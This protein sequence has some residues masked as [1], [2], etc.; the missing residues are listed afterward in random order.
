MQEIPA[1]L[2]FFVDTN[3]IYLE[4]EKSFYVH[5]KKVDEKTGRLKDTNQ[6]K[7]YLDRF[8]DRSPAHIWYFDYYLSG[9]HLPVDSN[10]I[11]K[12]ILN[13]CQNY[14][15]SI[16]QDAGNNSNAEKNSDEIYA[17]T[18]NF[19]TSSMDLYVLPKTIRKINNGF[20]V[21]V[22]VIT[23]DGEK[24]GNRITYLFYNNGNINESEDK[25]RWSQAGALGDK[26][27]LKSDKA[28]WTIYRICKKFL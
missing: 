8:G 19:F 27:K 7:F 12:E 18:W 22:K 11:A 13:V 21:D 26:R 17:C 4:S 3:T 10:N 16:L 5:V 9:K 6:W 24:S 2:I 1:D 15:K 14:N 23:S 20:S 28:E 25:V